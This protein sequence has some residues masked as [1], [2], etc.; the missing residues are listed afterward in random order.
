MAR[1][2]LVKAGLGSGFART[3]VTLGKLWRQIW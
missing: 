3:G 2:E 1:A